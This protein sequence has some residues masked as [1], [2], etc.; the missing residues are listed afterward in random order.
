MIRALVVLCVLAGPALAKPLRTS[1]FPLPRPEALMAPAAAE[2]RITS[3]L[4]PRTSPFPRP[5]PILDLEVLAASAEADSAE[6][7]G[8][9]AEEKPKKRVKKGKGLCS[10]PRLAGEKLEV[11]GTPGK[12]CGIADPVRLKA[13]GDVRL[14]PP[15]V[16]DCKTAVALADWLED[17]VIPE[18]RRSGGGLEGLKIASGYACRPR[19]NQAGN[20]LSEH[21]R[22]LAIDISAFELANG[23][24]VSVLADWGSGK[25]GRM[26]AAIR[27]KACGIFK[28]VLGPG[29]DRFHRDH[30]HLDV[31]ERRSGAW[32]K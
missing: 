3:D 13:V 16:I 17:A 25:N 5:R 31:S 20:R 19:N 21:G 11:I 27:K 7:P 6:K 24:K 22:G 15:A 23:S 18:L 32:C 9:I 12:G 2:V 8:D 14:N 30:L 28:T 1:P 26:L 10:D 29:S 4:A